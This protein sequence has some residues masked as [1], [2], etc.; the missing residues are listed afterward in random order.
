MGRRYKSAG[1]RGARLGAA[2][3]GDSQQQWTW[4]DFQS[5]RLWGPTTLSDVVSL[6]SVIVTSILSGV[7]LIVSRV[8]EISPM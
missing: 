1:R 3:C 8:L 4:D 6:A 2:S 5:P 7:C